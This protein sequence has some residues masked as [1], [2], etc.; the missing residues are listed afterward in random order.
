MTMIVTSLVN[1]WRLIPGY[2]SQS[3]DAMTYQFSRSIAATMLW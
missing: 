3:A 1:W 2:L